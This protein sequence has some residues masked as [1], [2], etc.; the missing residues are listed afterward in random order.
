[1]SFVQYGSFDTDLSGG[2]SRDIIIRGS[3]KN[4]LNQMIGS[5]SSTSEA[6]AGGG[7]VE[8]WR[9]GLWLIEMVHGVL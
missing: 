2:L 3:G 8:T 5:W 4:V 1:V 6:L 7:T 9:W